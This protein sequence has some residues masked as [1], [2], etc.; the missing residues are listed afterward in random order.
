MVTDIGF[1][2]FK[3]VHQLLLRKAVPLAAH[4]RKAQMVAAFGV[5]PECHGGSG[6]EFLK[7]ILKIGIIGGLLA[8]DAGIIVIQN[9]AW[10]LSAG[11]RKI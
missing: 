4:V 8:L 3:F 2:P 9:K 6:A 10:V 11:A 7:N 5:F 1:P